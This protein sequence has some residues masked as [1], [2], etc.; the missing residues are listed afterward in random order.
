MSN[1]F[2]EHDF[3]ACYTQ[4]CDTASGFGG[5]GLQLPQKR[6][7]LTSCICPLRERKV[8]LTHVGAGIPEADLQ[9]QVQSWAGQWGQA[10][11]A[12]APS[13]QSDAAQA[14]W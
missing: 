4:L 9:R 11:Q 5:F 14:P 12:W 7:R 8:S 1:V 3:I 6:L 13:G 2:Q 10:G